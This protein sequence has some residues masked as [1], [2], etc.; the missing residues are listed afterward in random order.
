MALIT[1]G[2]S[3]QANLF[4]CFAFFDCCKV[5]PFP[6]SFSHINLN[7]IYSAYIYIYGE[8]KNIHFVA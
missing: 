5:L 7:D 8:I 1:S 6:P 3:L 4:L 2:L